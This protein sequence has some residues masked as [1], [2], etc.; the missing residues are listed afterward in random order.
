MEGNPEQALDESIVPGPPPTGDNSESVP[1][2]D[3]GNGRSNLDDRVHG[4]SSVSRSSSVDSFGFARTSPASVVHPPRNPTLSQDDTGS[5][6]HRLDAMERQLLDVRMMLQSLLH[7]RA[8]PPPIVVPPVQVPPPPP[9][10]PTMAQMEH[11]LVPQQPPD[12]PY[13]TPR[14]VRMNHDAVPPSD[15]R[16]LNRDSRSRA[17]NPFNNEGNLRNPTVSFAHQSSEQAPFPSRETATTSGIKFRLA[18]IPKLDIPQ[19]CNQLEAALFVLNWCNSIEAKMGQSK[20]ATEDVFS[21]LDQLFNGQARKWLSNYSIQ[22]SGNGDWSLF[23]HALF[24]TFLRPSIIQAASTQLSMCTQGRSET[25]V[26]FYDRFVSL[27]RITV[28]DQLN[29]SEMLLIFP[30][31]TLIQYRVLVLS[32]LKSINNPSLENVRTALADLDLAMPVS[33]QSLEAHVA[34][35][36]TVDEEAFYYKAPQHRSKRS[37]YFRKLRGNNREMKRSKPFIDSSKLAYFKQKGRCW[38][39]GSYDHQLKSCPDAKSSYFASIIDLIPLM[40]IKS[41]K[42]NRNGLLTISQTQISLE[43]LGLRMN[44]TKRIPTPCF[45]LLMRSQRITIA[46]V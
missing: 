43:I 40:L 29:L 33:P 26:D 6:S 22:H 12:T 44:M 9:N 25:L 10:L 19:S 36:N 37:Q 17:T 38:F 16:F 14:P 8:Q 23:K 35:S 15:S 42:Q 21:F 11:V 4:H 20:I 45:L 27:W 39:C 1:V 13:Y 34:N 31:K 28:M 5:G 18:D 46:P 32:H 3:H 2:Q 30:Q 41:P 24:G 7:Q